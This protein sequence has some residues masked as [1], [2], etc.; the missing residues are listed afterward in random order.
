LKV[1]NGFFM[2]AESFFEFSRQ[3]DRLARESDVGIYEGYG[4]KSLHAQ[5][6]GESFIALFANRMSRRGIYVLDEPEAAL[7][8]QRQLAFLGLVDD[9]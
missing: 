7:S 8:P 2:R 9:R 1:S 3:I 6:H 4:G 5:S